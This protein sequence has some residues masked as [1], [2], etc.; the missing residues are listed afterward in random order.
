MSRG[1]NLLIGMDRLSLSPFSRARQLPVRSRIRPVCTATG[2]TGS[3][4]AGSPSVHLFLVQDPRGSAPS[5][6]TRGISR[7]RVPSLY[8]PIPYNSYG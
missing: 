4:R 6:R 2:A 3:E 1:K 5:T 8:L 7:Q